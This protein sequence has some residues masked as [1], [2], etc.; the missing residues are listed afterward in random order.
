MQREPPTNGKRLVGGPVITCWYP[1][2]RGHLPRKP[3]TPLT[4]PS[5]PTIPV[6]H[7]GIAYPVERSEYSRTSRTL[8]SLIGRPRS[9][10]SRIWQRSVIDPPRTRVLLRS[11]RTPSSVRRRWRRRIR[12]RAI[13][14]P[15]VKWEFLLLLLAGL[16]VARRTVAV[17]IGTR[18]KS[19]TRRKLY[20][21]FRDKV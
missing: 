2:P 3:S 12:K 10:L 5:D 9:P 16:I 13:R 14:R 18:P 21:Y 4:T 17:V 11:R 6:C 19:R 15:F 1:R 7:N 8:L 20:D